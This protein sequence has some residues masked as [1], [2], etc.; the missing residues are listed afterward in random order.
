MAIE[1][2]M[3]TM[4]QQAFELVVEGKTTIE[5]VI[6]SVYAPGLESGAA[7]EQKELPAGKREI[8]HGAEQLDKGAG[9][10][11]PGDSKLPPPP[12]GAGGPFAA[13]PANGG[14]GT[15]PHKPA[16]LGAST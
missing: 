1:E 15:N 10:V 7:Q 14:Q 9:Q 12:A 2:G 16:D 4:Q 3:R 8:G 5:D 11:G 6:R 13:G